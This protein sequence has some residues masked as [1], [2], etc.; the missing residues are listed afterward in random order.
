MLFLSISH[1]GNINNFRENYVNLSDAY[2]KSLDDQIQFEYGLK[3]KEKSNLEQLEA[4]QKECLV[5]KSK[6]NLHQLIIDRYSAYQRY[7][8]DT[9]EIIQ[10]KN[11]FKLNQNTAQEH[12]L[13]LKNEL[14]KTQFSC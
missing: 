11:E 6:M 1:A 2:F 3:G 7:M 14:K 9:D 13:A 4:K 12:Y 8:Q 5:E 10:T